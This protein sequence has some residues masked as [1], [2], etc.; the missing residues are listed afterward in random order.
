MYAF[1]LLT[2]SRMENASYSPKTEGVYQLLGFG[3]FLL[4]FFIIAFYFYFIRKSSI[5][6]DFIKKNKKDGR[7]TIQKK[8]FDIL[9]QIG[10]ILSGMLVRWGYLIYVYLPKL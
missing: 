1:R 9:L 10:I 7:E 5:Q 8:W 2:G 4:W 3:M 6:I